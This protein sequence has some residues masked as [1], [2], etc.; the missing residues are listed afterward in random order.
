MAYEIETTVLNI[1]KSTI[2]K[3][4]ESLDAKQIQDTKLIIN[5]Y[6]SEG[7]KEGKDSWYLR[8]RSNTE[9]KN[10]VTWKSKSNI[11][12][13]IRKHKEINFLTNENCKY[14]NNISK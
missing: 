6:R 13:I 3:K 5:W 4:L 2:I 9:G 10:E 8:I 14:K 1:N 11:Q 12:G 7:V